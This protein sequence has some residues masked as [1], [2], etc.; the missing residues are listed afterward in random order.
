[1]AQSGPPP[2]V[3]GR[4][5]VGF[6][7]GVPP[8]RVQALL[9]AAGARSVGQIPHIDVQIVQLP[10]QAS[11]VAAARAFAQR[12]EVAFSEPDRL[13]PPAMVP[14]DTY[15][16]MAWHL[17]KISAPT[18]WDTT[19]GSSSVTIAILDTGVDGTHPDLSPKI[20][21]GWN[22][23]DNNSNTSDVYGHGTA[24]AGTA[25]ACSNNGIGVASIAWNCKIM[26][27]RVADANGYATYSALASG[28]TY[29]ADHGARVANASFEASNSATID[30]AAQY[31]QGKGGVVTIAAGN[32]G[33]FNSSPDDPYVLTV[34]ATDSSDALASW[35]N[36]GNNVDL[37]AP[38][39]NV[40]TTLSG[41]G[42]G[43]GSGTS[44]SAPVVAGVAALV[45][46]VNPS[47]TA[48]QIQNVLKQSAD[49]L[50]AAG[51]DPSYGWGRVNAARAVSLA[52]GTSGGGGGGTADTTPPTVSF[53]SPAAAATVSGTVSVQVNAGDNVGVASVSFSVDG[54]S[55][56]SDTSS[57]YSFSWNTA[58]WSN[59]SHTLTAK[60]TDAVGNS[61]SASVTVTV[62]NAAPDSTAPTISITSP[63][64]GATVSGTNVSVLVSAADNVGVVKVELYVD[65]KLTATSTAA[66]FTTKWNVKNAAK[67]AHT[68]CCKAYDAAG[69]VGT[70]ATI[71]VYK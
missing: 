27:I 4:V 37:A 61:T 41:G 8:S 34:S 59:G 70:S 46:S 21:P 66:P 56:G 67:G 16:Y 39:V 50:G 51:W 15:Y 55:Q 63:K 6:K 12:P 32:E 45:I 9:A 43:T 57:P 65:G 22:F 7:H 3:P 10:P 49:D 19:C 71:T 47:L 2:F 58:G 44:F 53:G 25:A 69:N 11:E 60:A 17:S 24:V 62:S 36:T 18:A 26:P 14:N 48:T 29:A 40:A 30:S 13:V 33:T 31:L 20:V 23:Y 68:L 38:G 64:A 54:A 5:L 52:L 1:M 28:I 35:S 42:Y